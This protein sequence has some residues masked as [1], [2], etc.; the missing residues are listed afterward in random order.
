MHVASSDLRAVIANGIELRF[1][2]LGAVTFVE[3]DLAAGGSAGTLFEDP[4]SRPHWGFVMEGEVELHRGT[5][6][7]RLGPATA[8]HVPAGDPP[9]RFRSTGG[10]RLAA[11]EPTEP[12]LDLSDAGLRSLG[13]APATVDA[14]GL[15][16]SLVPSADEL[17]ALGDGRVDARGFVMGSLVLT[18]ARFGPKSGYATNPCQLSHWGIV[19]SG[20]IVLETADG[21]EMLGPG[22]V[23]ACPSGEPGHRLLAARPA[24]LIDYTPL[25]E[26]LRNPN[27]ADWRREAFRA[28]RGRHR[29]RRQVQIAEL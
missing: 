6:R 7:D 1:A 15:P 10:A 11:F 25:D 14:I 23:F 20:T 18:R 28:I 17:A 4:C 3:A 8:F 5:G 27:A 19:T 29:S 13:F 22:D 2:T 16:A 24:S 21:A 12:S 26:V 9:H